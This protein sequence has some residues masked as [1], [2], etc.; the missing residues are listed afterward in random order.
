MTVTD[1]ATSDDPAHLADLGDVDREREGEEEQRREHVAQ[2][3]EALLDLLADTA[4][5]R[6]R[7]PP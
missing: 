6:E 2:R 5:R 7:R 3:E 1:D 4:T